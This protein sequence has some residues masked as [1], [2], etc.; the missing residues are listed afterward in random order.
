MAEEQ[1]APQVSYEELASIED[2]FEQIDTEIMRKQYELSKSAYAKRKEAVAKIPHFWPLVLEAAP[3]EIDQFI[4]TND[5]RIIAE[6]LL[7][8]DVTRPELDDGKAGNPRSLKISFKFEPNDDFEDEVLEKTFWYRRASDGW[9]GLVSEPVKINWKKDK[10]LT[11]GLTDGAVKLFEARKKAGDMMS[12]T[13]PEYAALK[14]K[15]EHWSAMNTSFFTWFGWISGRRWVSAE[16]SEKA[17]AEHAEKKA[18]GKNGATEEDDDEEY[19][20]DEED[21]KEDDSDVEVH[22]AGEEFAISLAD[23]LWPNAIKYFTDAQEM[24][25]ISEGDFEEDFDEDDEEDGEPIDIA[26]L[27]K[28]DKKRGKSDGGPPSKKAK[29]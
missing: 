29:K 27:L 9:T 1:D 22:H 17:M 18:N 4:Q 16:E 14:E 7:E 15:V 2:Q 25:E 12:K 8:I 5:S 10:D 26:E 19:N 13:V 11:E 20:E 23:E 6:H 3:P 21:D 28:E 24:D